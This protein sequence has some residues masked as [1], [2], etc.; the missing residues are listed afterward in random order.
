MHMDTGKTEGPRRACVSIGVAKPDNLDRLPGATH[1][2]LAMIEWAT[3]AGFD[4]YL[5]TDQD[6]PVTVARVR[7]AFTLALGGD[8]ADP[9]DHL[10]VHFAGHGVAYG[11]EDQF[12][13]LSHWQHET[14]Q[15]IKL[16]LF[17]RLLQYYRP[18]RV[19][20]FIDA[21][22]TRQ[23]VSTEL[24]H[25]SGILPLPNEIP[26]EFLEDRFRAAVHGEK[27]F[28][29]RDSTGVARCMFSTVLLRAL[30]GKYDEAIDHRGSAAVVT[31][32][33]IFAAVS[34]HLPREAG[35]RKLT[36]QPSLKP[37]FVLPDDVYTTLPIAYEPPDLP[38]PVVRRGP[39][40][41]VA[42]WPETHLRQF[43]GEYASERGATYR[44]S[45]LDTGLVI[46]GA[47]R[48]RQ[49]Q[50]IVAP[51]NSAQPHEES[52]N[53]T[54]WRFVEDGRPLSM[55]S[56]LLIELDTG[57]WIGG[58]VVPKKII[59][60]TVN[61]RRV[62]ES[63]GAAAV[64][65]AA[66]VIYRSPDGGAYLD[67]FQR[68]S[69]ASE[70]IIARLRAG[71]LTSDD[72]L[73]V[74][75][76]IRMDKHVDPLLGTVAAYLYDALG[77][78]DSIRRIAWFYATSYVQVPFDVALLANL[79]G[80]RGPDGRLRVRIPAVQQREPRTYAE[81]EL[82]HYFGPT[83][84]IP[85]ALVA[86]GFPWLRQ[87]WALLQATRLPLHPALIELA[88]WLP[89]VLLPFPFTTLTSGAGR[90]LAALVRRGEIS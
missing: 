71:L 16:S 27:A 59:T 28:M 64:R 47:G 40:P 85:D 4:G 7:E 72:A 45:D 34:L 43:A 77:D 69:D 42:I 23:T 65:G 53:G 80:T 29:I 55:P 9:L 50:L 36:V 24:L 30:C 88:H 31:S 60:V 21:C 63:K 86:G 17:V 14:D 35:L 83:F 5:V 11:V 51:P 58:A 62:S 20:L 26:R 3:R 41:T 1:A 52:G 82:S 57:E 38:P 76:R 2:A 15:A 61:E 81:R 67:E 19:S 73:D 32:P 37:G 79:E 90:L 75:V 33:R 87:G 84:D 68:A 66:S 54:L 46:N 13:L 49:Q 48:D 89:D 8:Q 25:G 44:Y 12:L 70:Q 22:R 6:G 39:P 74:A 10:I 56:S 18:R 78:R